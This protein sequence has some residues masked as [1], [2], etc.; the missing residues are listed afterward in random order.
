M[1]DT[2]KAWCHWKRKEIEHDPTGPFAEDNLELVKAVEDV[3]SQVGT[4]KAKYE[5]AKLI[6]DEL[7]VSDK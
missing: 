7:D 3:I 6:L 5:R 4:W 2:L 1:S